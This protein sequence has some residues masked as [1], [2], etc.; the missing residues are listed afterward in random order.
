MNPKP[1]PSKRGSGDCVLDESS[2]KEQLQ[3]DLASVQNRVI[4]KVP[5]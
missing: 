2:Q 1:T 4:L 5:P 3:N